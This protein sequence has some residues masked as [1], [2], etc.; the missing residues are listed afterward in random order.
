MTSQTSALAVDIAS[1]KKMTNQLLAAAAS[2]RPAERVVR[3]ADG[4][5]ASAERIGYRSSR[6]RW[7]ATTGAAWA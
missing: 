7:T 3:D 6:S 4:A 1:D 5:V 2:P